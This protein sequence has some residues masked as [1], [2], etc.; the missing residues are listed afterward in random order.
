MGVTLGTFRTRKASRLTG[1][2]FWHEVYAWRRKEPQQPD[3]P[4]LEQPPLDH[5]RLTRCFRR[6]GTRLWKCVE[7]LG[8][9]EREDALFIPVVAVIP[10]S[11]SREGVQRGQT[12]PIYCEGTLVQRSNAKMHKWIDVWAVSDEVLGGVIEDPVGR[13]AAEPRA[14]E[15]NLRTI[16]QQLLRIWLRRWMVETLFPVLRLKDLSDGILRHALSATIGAAEGRPGPAGPL[17]EGQRYGSGGFTPRSR[18]LVG[19]RTIRTRG[20][21]EDRNKMGRGRREPG[22]QFIGGIFGE[23][24]PTLCVRGDGRFTLTYRMADRFESLRRVRNS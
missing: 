16:V 24:G 17:G 22:D 10:L 5:A 21:F 1:V 11:L 19:R 6:R 20:R 4:D 3:A 9:L 13:A 2:G 14:G 7:P 12:T 18:S 23:P 8:P 15:R